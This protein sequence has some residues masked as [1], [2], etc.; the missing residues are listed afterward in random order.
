MT[1][2]YQSNLQELFRA[3]EEANRM[4]RLAEEKR[5]K[6]ME[7]AIRDAETEIDNLREQYETEFQKK[8]S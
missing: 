5:E 7:Q 4:I 6:I 1:S 8:A 2:A 3:E